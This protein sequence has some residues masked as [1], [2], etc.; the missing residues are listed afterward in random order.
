MLHPLAHPPDLPS[1]F[2]RFTMCRLLTV[3]GSLLLMAGLVT[4][5][6][7]EP[8]TAPKEAEVWWSPHP[9]E[10]AAPPGVSTAKYAVWPRT[11]IDRFVLAKRLK[12]GREPAP[13]ADGRTLLRRVTF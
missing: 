2:R 3:L 8:S 5:R 9:I 1:V 12:K 4:S 10:K 11:P 7:A 6:A 13:P